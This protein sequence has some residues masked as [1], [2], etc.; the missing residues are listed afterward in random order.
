M[1]LKVHV[2]NFSFKE[3]PEFWAYSLLFEGMLQ[4]LSHAATAELAP[5]MEIPGVKQVSSILFVCFHTAKS[6][7]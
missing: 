1:P 6:R 5:L 4:K 2:E 7:T 3:L